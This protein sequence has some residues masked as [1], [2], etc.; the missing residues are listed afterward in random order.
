MRI[1]H[2]RRGD[3]V[4]N[5]LVPICIGILLAVCCI[6]WLNKKLQPQILALAETQLK[7]EITQ[8][9]NQSVQSALMEGKGRELTRTQTEG[10]GRITILTADTS[11]LNTLRLRVVEDLNKLV[12][13]PERCAFD[14]PLGSITGLDFLS[15]HGPRLPVQ[16]LSVSSVKADFRSEFQSAGINQTLHRMMMDVDVQTK[17]LLPGGA[18]CIEINTPVCITETIIIAPVPNVLPSDAIW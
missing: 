7:N 10:D 4:I 13:M 11:L 9:A 6:H 8:I 14:V 3:K 12:S 16:I 2:V 17:L 5:I 1:R 15:G 18:T